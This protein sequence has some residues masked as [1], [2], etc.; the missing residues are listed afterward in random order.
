MN[1]I[2]NPTWTEA[3]LAAALIALVAFIVGGVNGYD[4]RV[5]S[6]K[7]GAIA[8]CHPEAK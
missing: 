3:T 7:S 5:H 6:E 4:A 1:E 2:R 8:G